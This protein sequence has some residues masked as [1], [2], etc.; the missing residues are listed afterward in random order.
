MPEPRERSGGKLPVHTQRLHLHFTEGGLAGV[1]D[2]RRLELRGAGLAIGAF[3]E[4]PEL[5]GGRR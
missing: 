1:P 3:Q 4:L 2:A 5:L